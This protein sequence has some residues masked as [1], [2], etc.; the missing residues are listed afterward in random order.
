MRRSV[1]SARRVRADRYRFALDG[2]S[3]ALFVVCLALV[4]VIAGTAWQVDA[5][6]CKGVPEMMDMCRV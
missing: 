3:V 5:A 6:V 4:G 2:A 1:V